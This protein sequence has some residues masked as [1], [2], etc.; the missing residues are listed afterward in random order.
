MKS[1]KLLKLHQSAHAG[2]LNP[3]QRFKFLSFIFFFGSC[4]VS[5]VPKFDQ[6]I[7]DNLSTSSIE[8]FQLFAEVSAGTS[9]SDYNLR[10]EKYNSI[11]GKCEALELQIKARPFPKNKS[12][13]KIAAKVNDRLK[14]TGE[15]AFISANDTAPSATALHQIIANL[16]K[17]KNTDKS[18]GLTKIEVDTFK[19]FITLYIDQALTYEK[20]LSE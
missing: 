16:V 11:I 1:L 3:R 9:K 17:M 8:V 14:A 20:F 2:F 7:V 13:D 18:Q 10:D 6:T 15:T 4:I 5:L 19:G 12:V